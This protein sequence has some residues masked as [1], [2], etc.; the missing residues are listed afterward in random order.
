[1]ARDRG[2]SGSATRRLYAGK[3][4]SAARERGGGSAAPVAERAQDRIGA[5]GARVGDAAAV[6]CVLRVRARRRH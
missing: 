5:A 4:E 2:G 1:V 6:L 3:T